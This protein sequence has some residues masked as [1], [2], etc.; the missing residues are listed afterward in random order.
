MPVSTDLLD[1]YLHAV[2]FWLPKAQQQDILAELAEDLHSQIDDRET[3]LGRPLTED[4]LAGILRRRGSPLRVA[5][6]YLPEQRLI[7]PAMVPAYR[8]VLQ[9]VLLWVLLPLFVIVFAGPLL[10]STHP[11]RV[12]LQFFVEAV[13][14]A[15]TVAG[16]VTLVFAVLDRYH[17][18][19]AVDRWEPRKLP[20]VQAAQDTASRW[21]YFA[22]G[23]F[24]M[25]AAGCWVWLF[26][27]RTG[28]DFPGGPR[29]TPGPVWS[30][31]YAPVLA[32]TLTSASADLLAFLHPCWGTVR[33]R[34]RIGIDACFLAIAI[35]LLTAGDWVRV[36]DAPANVTAWINLSVQIT[37]IATAVIVAGDALLELRRILRTPRVRTAAA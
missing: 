32:L 20:R 19:Q 35:L 17:G 26:W 25:L 2:K 14:T 18:V 12:V 8:L 27:Q 5:S 11:E 28:F 1:R 33:S 31:I 23:I 13:R 36:S 21:N 16:I 3:A 6:G 10:T 24:G 34:V 9:I 15:F 30:Y 37:L 22:G 29:I 4:E 7:H